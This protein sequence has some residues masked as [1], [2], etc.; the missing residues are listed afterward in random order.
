MAAY[1]FSR[2]PVTVP[3][4]DTAFRN[5]NTPIPTLGTK[6][7]LENLE[8]NESR[9][10]H[11][12]LPIIWDRAEDFSVFDMAGNKWIDFTSTI[13]VAN[14]G[15]SN[16]R[17]TASIKAALDYPL[18]SCYAYANPI[19]ARYLEK[20]IAFAGPPFEKAFLLSAG[21]EAT[22]A[23]LKLMRMQGQKIGK[24]RRGIICVEGNWHGRTLGAQMMSSNL[25]QREWIGYQDADIHHIPFPYPW[26]LNGRD[27]IAFLEEGLKRLSE[28]GVDLAQDV[29]GFM[30]ETFQGWGAVFY[31]KE[32][33]QVIEHLC[34]KHQILLT[35]DEM[36][37]GFGRTGKAFGYQHYGV[38]PDL[39]C[40]GKG[41]GGG[42]PLAGVI[43]RAEIMDLPDVGNMSST[44]SAN[45]LVCAAGLAVIEELESRN[46][47]AE[48]AR[49]GDLLFRGLGDL[50]LRFPDRI[51]QLLGIGLI[52]AVVF[53]SPLT[54]E[55][56]GLFTS[57]VAERCMQKGLLVVHTGRE[58]IKLGPPLT[59][60]DAALFEG[61][62]VLGESIAEIASV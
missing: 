6:E 25:A 46:L 58:S 18:Y 59:I 53:R 10:M 31:P 38:T 24:R 41:M 40:C 32:F 60:T 8:E 20:L 15:H 30:L 36:Q 29:C 43:G 48:T 42:V 21:T 1:N 50:Q 3:K 19:R 7:I 5:I 9:S 16:A 2:T 14:V 56:D 55:A 44:H 23:A 39:I 57:R 45:P 17:V 13:F 28:K 62:D 27:P 4:V 22:E 35:F 11:G 47:I 52:A 51:S 49:K 61:I 37:A 12:Q 33:V 34:Q 26:V 54:G